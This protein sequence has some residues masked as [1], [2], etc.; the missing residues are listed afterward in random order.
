MISRHPRPR[1]HF[2]AASHSASKT[3]VNAL[4]ALRSI[5]GTT[6]APL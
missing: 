6:G 1:A 2:D 5:R 4:M 3:G